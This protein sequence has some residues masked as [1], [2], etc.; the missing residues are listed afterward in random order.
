MTAATMAVCQITSL[1]PSD[2]RIDEIPDPAAGLN[3][4]RAELAPQ[5]GHVHVDGVRH[6]LHVVAVEMFS[7]RSAINH[8]AATPNEQFEDVVLAPGE[9]D[10]RAVSEDAASGKIDLQI[11]DVHEWRRPSRRTPNQ[12]VQPCHQ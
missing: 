5:R 4:R 3:E 2:S 10:L 9:L 8:G 12:G 11:A 6:E 7:Q 1:A